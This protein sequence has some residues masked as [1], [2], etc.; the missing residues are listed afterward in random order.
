MRFIDLKSQYQDL[1]AEIDSNIQKVLDHGQYVLGPE[2]KESERLLAD[3]TGAEHALCCSSGTDALML[4]MMAIGIKPGDEVIVPGFSFFATAEVPSLLGAVPVFVD[5]EPDSCL[6]DVSKIEEKITSKTRAIVPVGLY[7]QTADMD[8]I[9]AIAEKHNL[10][11]VEDAA[12][13]FGAEY[14]GK[15]SGN[16]AHISGTSFF[17]AK[18]LGV[19]GDGGAVFTNDPEIAETMRQLRMHGESSRYNHKRIGLNAR[20]DSIQCAV[21]IPKL[22][23]FPSEIEK[24]A[25]AAQRYDEYL[26]G[27]DGLH[28]VGTKA[29]RTNVFAQYTLIAKGHRDSLREYLGEKNIPTAIHYP[30]PM[31]AQEC[32]QE[33]HGDFKL[34]NCEMLSESVMSL[35]MHPYLEGDLQKGIA[36]EIHNYF[37]KV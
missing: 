21:L 8:E 23:A 18:P 15:R 7:G 33:T 5:V 27:I 14:K 20:M 30:K 11:V 9:N 3:F 22:K 4:G 31:Y 28:I 36:D 10:V 24:R 32:Y 13:S 25:Q 6:I 2:V 35:P 37:A 34:E 16:V 1:K 26:K 29:D 12:Q 17:P 19:Y